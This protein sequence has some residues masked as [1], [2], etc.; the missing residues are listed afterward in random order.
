MIDNE[1]TGAEEVT[2]EETS[3]ESKDEFN[4]D[5]L[6]RIMTKFLQRQLAVMPNRLLNSL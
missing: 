6:L 5:E 2:E 3:E 1:P 4:I